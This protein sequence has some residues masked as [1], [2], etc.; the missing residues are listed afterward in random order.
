MKK[1]KKNFGNTRISASKSSKYERMEKYILNSL[2]TDERTDILAAIE[3][4]LRG[5]NVT[6]MLTVDEK[7]KAIMDMLFKFKVFVTKATAENLRKN[8]VNRE[9]IQSWKPGKSESFL[10][11]RVETTRAET[12]KAYMAQLQ[13]RPSKEEI[14]SEYQT[15]I[16]NLEKKLTSSSRAGESRAYMD[17]TVC[18]Y[19][20]AVRRGES[21]STVDSNCH[22]YELFYNGITGAVD[23]MT[24]WKIHFKEI[25]SPTVRSQ[26]CQK[27]ARFCLLTK[28]RSSSSPS[29][30]YVMDDEDDDEDDCITSLPSSL[31]DD[32][33]E[34]YPVWIPTAENISEILSTFIDELKALYQRSGGEGDFIVPIGALA[35]FPAF[36]SCFR[37]LTTTLGFKTHETFETREER[38]F[39]ANVQMPLGS[40]RPPPVV[41]KME[42]TLTSNAFQR[43]SYVSIFYEHGSDLNQATNEAKK[44][45]GKAASLLQKRLEGWAEK[46]SPELDEV[47]DLPTDTRSK[48]DIHTSQMTRREFLKHINCPL[49]DYVDSDYTRECAARFIVHFFVEIAKKLRDDLFLSRN[50]SV[51]LCF[52]FGDISKET[53]IRNSKNSFLV[54]LQNLLHGASGG[55][56]LIANVL[57]RAIAEKKFIECI[58]GEN[59]ATK[60]WRDMILRAVSIVKP[61]KGITTVSK[62]DADFPLFSMSARRSLENF[63]Y[64]GT[65]LGEKFHGF[66]TL[67]TLW[68]ERTRQE[69]DGKNA[70]FDP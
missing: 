6:K 16:E 39:S 25:L 29:D 21:D 4:A 50:P 30:T 8:G 66:K 14:E 28:P 7:A 64:L 67:K 53:N 31:M 23:P 41:L 55:E 49:V 62:F 61:K 37:E 34:F 51:R 59:T 57:L 70:G 12:I 46:Y 27:V 44:N 40:T 68:T 69:I 43:L 58:I 13:T 26:T 32:F 60:V 36:L 56:E 24:R 48:Y 45:I 63:V 3:D 5:G 65:D 38:K 52:L 42:A 9:K 17:K 11:H 10:E 54:Q 20:Y 18:N 2:S 22:F 33:F 19:A 47:M 35:L 1:N 15:W